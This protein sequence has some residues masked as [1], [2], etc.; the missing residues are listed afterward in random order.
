MKRI[1]QQTAVL[2]REKNSD[3]N[4]NV[5]PTLVFLVQTETGKK[6]YTVHVSEVK[7]NRCS[8]F[9]FLTFT[10]RNHNGPLSLDPPLL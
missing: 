2:G 5:L 9:K 6:C 3:H 7:S 1:L 4:A 10:I 8:V